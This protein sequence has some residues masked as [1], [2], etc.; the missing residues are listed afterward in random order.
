MAA[1]NTMTTL[2]DKIRLRAYQVGFG[3]CFLLSFHYSQQIDGRD[4]RHVLIDFGSVSHPSYAPNDL[5]TQIAE[6]IKSETHGKL[7]AVVA[8][9]RHR[10][11]IDGFTTN[12]SKTASGDIIRSLKPNLVIQPWTEDPKAKTTATG[13]TQNLPSKQAFIAAL[14]G[15]HAVAAQAIIL[16]AELARAAKRRGAAG[17][18]TGLHQDQADSA[19]Q[20]S[21][22]GQNNLANRSAVDNLMTMAPNRYVYFGVDSGLE[23]LLPGVDVQV[24]GPPTLDQA[25]QGTQ[26]NIRKQRSRDANE[27]WQFQ[28]D[29]APRAVSEKRLLFPRAKTLARVPLSAAWLLRRLRQLSQD[30]F[31]SL[32]RSLD[33]QMN[34]T[35]VILLF[36]IGKKKL[37]FPGDAQIENWSYA[38]FDAPAK[39]RKQIAEDLA[40]VELYKVGHHG[41]MNATPKTLWNLFKHK[42]ASGEDR[43]KTV[44]STM[45]GTFGSDDAGT[46]V[47]R[48][49]LVKELEAKS[50]LFTTEQIKAPKLWDDIDL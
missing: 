32:V 7:D 35:S 9:H 26:S 17:N 44:M 6:D 34:N 38:L 45:H 28:A 21:F 11:H 10:D 18:G 27:F 33:H 40:D 12:E 49:K 19:T 14:D 30:Q 13:P 20:L 42:G 43:L 1:R 4:E 5:L 3:D 47:P 8:T 37:L 23:K 36:T 25:D 22:L 41:S 31:L 48:A 16:G 29:A 39:L 15:M 24:L 2:P 50:N 46:E